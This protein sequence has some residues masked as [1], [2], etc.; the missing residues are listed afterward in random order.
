EFNKYLSIPKLDINLDYDNLKK[1]LDEFIKKGK[2]QILPFQYADL[3]SIIPRYF[4][5]EK[6]FGLGKKKHEFPDAIVLSAIEVWCEKQDCEIY[7]VSGDE[8]LNSITSKRVTA[9]SSLRDILDRINRQYEVDRIKWFEN[10]F[11][12]SKTSIIDKI[13]DKFK[14]EIEDQMSFDAEISNVKTYDVKLFKASIVQDN[15]ET[16]EVI[17]QLDVDIH[18]YAD[19]EHEDFDN[20]IY[21]SE[22]GR[23]LTYG[24]K[25]RHINASTTQTVEISIEAFMTTRFCMIQMTMMLIAFIVVSHQ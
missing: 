20:G 22:E 5:H 12:N 3:N 4:N 6:P 14:E 9:V 10:L 2:V 11:S 25:T 15:K 13:K 18:F 19:I 1:Q 7:L 24:R 23:W 16:G 21:D 8:D 17:F